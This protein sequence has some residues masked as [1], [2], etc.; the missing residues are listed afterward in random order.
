MGDGAL[1]V[2]K[3]GSKYH[4]LARLFIEDMSAKSRD[5]ILVGRKVYSEREW[6]Q[7]KIHEVERLGVLGDACYNL[8]RLK[9][10]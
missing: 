2:I 10:A 3:H 9:A 6:Q 1:E 8:G 4:Y 7:K 5:H